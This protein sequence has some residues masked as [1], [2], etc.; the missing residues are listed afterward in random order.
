MAAALGN[1]SFSL[2]SSLRLGLKVLFI[3]SYAAK[4]VVR[5]GTLPVAMETLA[6]R[7]RDLLAFE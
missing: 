7:I 3:T 4:A 2:A 5:H 6:N 1:S